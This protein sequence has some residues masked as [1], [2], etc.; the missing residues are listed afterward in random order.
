[1]SKNST[2]FIDEY[3]NEHE[4]DDNEKELGKGGQGIVFRTRD[5]DLA[6]KLVTDENATPI[7]SPSD[8]KKYTERFKRVRLLPL[9]DGVNISTPLS[10]LTG[11]HAGY[12][13]HLLSD[14]IPFDHFWIDKKSSQQIIESDIPEWLMQVPKDDAKKIIHYK[15]TGGLRRRLEALYLCATVLAR[16][17]GNGL[18][19]GDISP[20]NIFISENLDDLSVWLIDADNIRFEINQGGSI[21]YTPKYGAPELV[22]GREGV[23]PLSD[24]H[25]FA[26]VAFYM[27]S[28]VH[29]FM[30]KKANGED[31]SDWADDESDEG[32]NEEKALKGMFP[33]IDDEE[34]DSNSTSDGLPRVL[35]I[36]PELTRL[37]NLIF[38][39]GRTKP[40]LRPTIYHWPRA[41]AQA[42]D[43]T[44]Q[45]PSC[46]MTYYYDYQDAETGKY[47][48]PYCKTSRTQHLKID[49]YYWVEK[50]ID[51][52]SPCWSFIRELKNNDKPIS[53]PRRL[54]SEFTM[55]ESNNEELLISIGNSFTLIKKTG[56]KNLK[57][58][59]ALEDSIKFTDIYSKIRIEKEPS[60]IKFWMFVNSDIPRLLLCSIIGDEG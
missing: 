53:I 2:K 7:T 40:W 39:A 42:A 33:W 4:K 47:Q 52:D 43:N 17:N 55:T 21:V 56:D 24:C 19:Y 23:S 31:D 45:C 51:F 27:L 25:A 13:M 48:C 18:V 35:L 38:G 36:T 9:P 5:P 54:F 22:Q 46:E 12:V 32:D 29:P 44:I 30:G 37:F 1:M 8:I 49:S 16:L 20:N 41:F 14:M 10:L 57:I 11:N 15:N 28:L 60:E 3:F 50:E 34:D 59:F 6:I 26:V 58:A